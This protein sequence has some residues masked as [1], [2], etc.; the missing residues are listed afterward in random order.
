MIAL[1]VRLRRD[2]PVQHNNLA[3]RDLCSDVGRRAGGRLVGNGVPDCV[4]RGAF[5]PCHVDG[6]DEKR[7]GRPSLRRRHLLRLLVLSHATQL[8]RVRGHL[9]PSRR[10][11]AVHPERGDVVGNG[12]AGRWVRP[13]QDKLIGVMGGAQI[14]GCGRLLARHLDSL[15]HLFSS[16]L[17]AWACKLSAVGHSPL[18]RLLVHMQVSEEPSEDRVGKGK[19]ESC[20]AVGPKLVVGFQ[21]RRDVQPVLQR[22]KQRPGQGIF[23]RRCA[24]DATHRGFCD[25]RLSALMLPVNDKAVPGREVFRVVNI[26]V[27]VGLRH[28][29]QH[30]FRP[31]LLLGLRRWD[32]S[33]RHP[34]SK[35]RTTS[36]RTPADKHRVGTNCQWE[37]RSVWS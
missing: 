8:E 36:E 5:L 12:R 11:L 7:M 35:Q 1:H 17:S 13:R 32:K 15:G 10:R 4:A 37:K 3:L 2:G 31:G 25:P 27:S 34:T 9:L 6:N 22:A 16:R 33:E 28:H 18:R 21:G 30:F 19:A 20:C 14:G 26:G 29:A 23:K 24:L